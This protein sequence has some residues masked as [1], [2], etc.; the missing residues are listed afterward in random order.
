MRFVSKWVT[1]IM[2]H[3]FRFWP[4]MKKTLAF[5]DNYLIFLADKPIIFGK[6]STHLFEWNTVVTTICYERFWYFI[7]SFSKPNK[8]INHIFFGIQFSNLDSDSLINC[9]CHSYVC[10]TSVENSIIYLTPVIWIFGNV[11]SNLQLNYLL[12]FFIISVLIVMFL[13]LFRKIESDAALRESRPP[14]QYI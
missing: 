7:A 1:I 8:E 5:T 12:P 6:P 11:K 3:C 13:D 10:I 9:S 2:V 14:C 4:F